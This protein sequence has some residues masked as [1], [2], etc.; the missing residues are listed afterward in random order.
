MQRKIKY[1]SFARLRPAS[2]ASSA[3][4]ARN[5]REGGRAELLLRRRL[6]EDGLRFTTQSRDLPG[7][8]DIVFVGSRVCV[9]CD[10]DFW[11]GRRWATARQALLSRHN[12]DYWVA[13]IQSNRRRDRVVNRELRR[14]GWTVLRFWESDVLS[15]VERAAG[16]V[17]A[18]TTRPCG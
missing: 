16:R 1:P 4:M 13:K 10:G 17:R 8:P 3:R 12:S 6:R 5:R 2:E 9:F 18:A 14:L 15:N 11:H 7:V